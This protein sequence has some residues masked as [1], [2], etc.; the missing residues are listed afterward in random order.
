[1]GAGVPFGM[2]YLAYGVF[3]L[4]ALPLLFVGLSSLNIFDHPHMTEE[5][6]LR[7]TIPES[8]DYVNVFDD[9]FD[10]YTKENKILAVKTKNMGSLYEI[11]YNVVFKQGISLKQFMDE[12]RI[13]NGNLE[14]SCGRPATGAD[15]L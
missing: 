5:L 15:V 13:R 9:L 10:T 1:M 7:V 6:L 4:F 8:L 11:R 12:I 2:G 3:I 14:V